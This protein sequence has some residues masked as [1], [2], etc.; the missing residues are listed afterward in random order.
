MTYPRHISNCRLLFYLLSNR[1][2]HT[3]VDFLHL[4]WRLHIGRHHL[5]W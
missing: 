4:W 3:L 2:S 1:S 5:L